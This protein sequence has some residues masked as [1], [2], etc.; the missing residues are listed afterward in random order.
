MSPR[1]IKVI[2]NSIRAYNKQAN[3][4]DIKSIEAKLDNGELDPRNLKKGD[5]V[6]LK[7]ENGKEFKVTIEKD[8]E[9]SCKVRGRDDSVRIFV[10]KNHKGVDCICFRHH[11]KK[12]E[13]NFYVTMSRN[14]PIEKYDKMIK[15]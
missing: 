15:K 3:L 14:I 9:F 13:S 4:P 11:Y 5:V 1:D 7:L 2:A 6:T 10:G 12:T 8:G